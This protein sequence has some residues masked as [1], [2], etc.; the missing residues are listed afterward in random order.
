M[1]RLFSE[2][3]RVVSIVI[4]DGYPSYSQSVKN[5]MCGHEIVQIILNLKNKKGHHTNNIE[6]L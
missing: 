3:V 5:A 6:N 4:T 1:T 2:Y